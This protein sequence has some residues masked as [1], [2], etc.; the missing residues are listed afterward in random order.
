MIAFPDEDED[1]GEVHDLT[2][3]IRKK[4]DMGGG[5]GVESLDSA[6]LSAP[7]TLVLK[8]S[9]SSACINSVWPSRLLR[10]TTP[11]STNKSTVC[12]ATNIHVT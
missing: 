3:F 7:V 12:C 8:Y 6:E 4:V 9:T 11:C 2:E 5:K 10:G 1:E